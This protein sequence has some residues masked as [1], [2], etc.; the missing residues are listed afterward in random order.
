LRRSS[1]V[2]VGLPIGISLLTASGPAAASESM[3]SICSRTSSTLS[4]LW[5]E[6]APLRVLA[7]TVV[8]WQ[9]VQ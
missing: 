1:S 7:E 5:S 8:A 9:R 4:K 3:C 2:G 6:G